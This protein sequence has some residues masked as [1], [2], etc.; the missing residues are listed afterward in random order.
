MIIKQ[1]YFSATTV[2]STVTWLIAA[3]MT[4]I[5]CL[6]IYFFHI[7]DSQTKRETLARVQAS[8][9]HDNLR[10]V[11]LS[12]EYTSWMLG[13]E[14]TIVQHDVDWMNINYKE[15][16]P[17]HYNLSFI[18]LVKA[19]HTAELLGKTDENAAKYVKNIFQSSSINKKIE[20]AKKRDKQFI[21]QTFFTVIDDQVFYMIADPFVDKA[22]HNILDSSL[23]VFARKLEPKEINR[24]SKEYEL[25]NL[26]LN[27]NAKKYDGSVLLHELNGVP[28][29]R[30][31]WEVSELNELYLPYFVV[32]LLLILGVSILIVRTVLERD[33]ENRTQYEHELYLA[34]TTDPLTQVSNKRYVSSYA[35]SQIKLHEKLD[36]SISFLTLD[37]DYFK[38]INDKFGHHIGDEALI[39]FCKVCQE[40]IREID[41]LGRIGGE[42]FVIIL[43]KVDLEEAKMVAE[44]I[45][46]SINQSP[47]STDRGTI[48]L[49]VS[50]GVTTHRKGLC[51]SDLLKEADDALYKAKKNGR[52]QVVVF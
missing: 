33:L 23:L 26:F 19:D 47:M 42:E 18:A 43:P 31:S 22:T 6:I 36:F 7:V 20:L 46:Q 4:V 10:M 28:V 21:G 50:I 52:N 45:C 27:V 15:F 13:F 25:P 30:L 8:I 32:F 17:Q 41:V 44:R 38:R 2:V 29:A 11:D 48:H 3:M 12:Y 1:K 14:K 37:L 16:L 51:F 35:E 24:F 49:S 39:H 34:A 9:K 5:I 40:N